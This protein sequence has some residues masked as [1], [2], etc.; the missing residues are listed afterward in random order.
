MIH[1]LLKISLPSLT[2]TMTHTL[3]L[4]AAW[5]FMEE[6]ERRAIVL[7]AQNLIPA[8][9]IG[10]HS[11]LLSSNW[12]DV[13]K[14]DLNLLPTQILSSSSSSRSHSTYEGITSDLKKSLS[15]DE[16]N[17]LLNHINNYVQKLVDEK[18]AN[19]RKLSVERESA[20]SKELMALIGDSVRANVI[21]SVNQAQSDKKRD[22]FHKLSDE[23]VSRIVELV[24]LQLAS[25]ERPQLGVT[26]SQDNLDQITLL[27]KQNIEAH[28]KSLNVI[29][30]IAADE[31]LLKLLSSPK[32]NEFIKERITEG[33]PRETLHQQQV[34]IDGLQNEIV[35]LKSQLDSNV[36]DDEDLR[37]SIN[38]LY[39]NY[40]SFLTQLNE[41][42]MNSTSRF[43]N[44]LEQMDAKIIAIYSKQSSTIDRQIKLVLADI[45]GY[46]NGENIDEIDLREW[47]LNKFV[48]KD[49]LNERLSAISKD[50]NDQIKEELNR[51]AGLFMKDIMEKVKIEILRI[52]E[53]REKEHASEKGSINWAEFDDGELRAIIRDVLA[54]YD[55][56]KT[57]RV[58]YAL[59]SA[60]GQVLSTRCTENYQT[61]SAQISIFG[62]PLWYPTNTPRTAISPSVQ[63]GECWAFQGF[64]G[65]LGEG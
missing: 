21:A 28:N 52:I 18:L 7:R 19:E 12:G 30:R 64:P 3:P 60:G 47:A 1:S 27:I 22:G 4:F 61:K 45:L 62:I 55:A 6:Q 17:R 31:L 10:F 53:V 32:F 11:I 8:S 43:D 59:E 51:F 50:S 35:S 16:Y 9:L 48:T 54:V 44:L 23:D 20:L 33:S 24:V 26:L 39:T 41:M 56:D 2:T 29:E 42:E 25:R 5:C 34:L 15:D 38:A 46:K 36:A 49:L 63:P 40:N 57:G 14:F 13:F 65:F 58:D 37:Q